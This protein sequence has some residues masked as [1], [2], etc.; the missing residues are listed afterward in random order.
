MKDACF[1]RETERL[2]LRSP[3]VGDADIL[4]AK[5]ST[6]FVMRYNL[7][8]P[9]D[10]A[11]IEDELSRFEHIVLFEKESK[12]VIGCVAV[13]DDYLR[14]R[15]AS[16]SLQAWL[17]EDMAHRGYMA[18]ALHAILPYLF[19]EC[20]YE[21]I[22]IQIFADNRASLR[23]AEKLGFAREGY[24]ER[25]VQNDDGQVFD[26][27]LLSLDFERYKKSTTSN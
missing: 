20:E 3:T 17:S 19:F 9:C 8:K 21:R 12:A 10:R 15:V 6:G 14:Y 16:V 23:L 24:L 11:Q 1:Y 26:V 22:A 5:R 7:Y 25:A 27:V 2:L 4:A 18:E 13:K